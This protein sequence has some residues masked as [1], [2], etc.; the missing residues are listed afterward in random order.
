[1]KPDENDDPIVETAP[2]VVRVAIEV[3]THVDLILTVN[4][5]EVMLD[6]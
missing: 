5:V 3:P 2:P 4:G 1:M 6:E